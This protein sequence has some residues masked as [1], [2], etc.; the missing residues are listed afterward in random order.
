MN[1]WGLAGSGWLVA[2]LLITIPSVYN[3][4]FNGFALIGFFHA[5]TSKRFYD[6]GD[7]GVQYVNSFLIVEKEKEKEKK[8]P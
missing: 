2:A 4:F 3:L 1:Q 6:L 5:I 7:K 8:P